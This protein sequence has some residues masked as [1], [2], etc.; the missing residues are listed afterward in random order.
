MQDLTN[1]VREYLDYYFTQVHTSIPGIV[2]E[3]E[4]AA[5]RATV[6]PSLKRR[7]GNKEFIPFPLL[8]DVP[9]LFP[10]T[11]KWTIHF[12]LEKGDEVAVF[13][14]E[15]SL[16]EWKESGQDG[17]EDSD[18]R[19]YDLC[20]AY[21]IPGLQP[22]EF[23]NA[24]EPGLQI[25]HNDTFDGECISQVLMTDDK[26]EIKYKEKAKITMED[27][28]IKADTEKCHVDMSAQKISLTNGQ[29]KI[30]ADGGNVE[31]SAA[32]KAIIKSSQVE[33]TGG[34]FSMKGAVTASTGPLCAIP[35]C[36]FTGA[37]HGGSEVSG[38]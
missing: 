37:P 9:V 21:C 8:I 30:I 11:K 38:T 14:S 19:R 32:T 17:I 26:I 4:P 27:D 16:D 31:V 24:S 5:R 15:R 29:D 12:P 28:N 13:F 22:K 36:L 6:Q 10:G 34:K 35:N 18:P 25:I 7:A 33:I 23:I 1:F 20:D 2:T 3:Y